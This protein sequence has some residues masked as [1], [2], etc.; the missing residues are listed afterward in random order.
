MLINSKHTTANKFYLWSCF[1][2]NSWI[3]NL[4]EFKIVYVI[5]SMYVIHYSFYLKRKKKKHTRHDR[6]FWWST[7]LI[8]FFALKTDYVYCMASLSRLISPTDE[9]M[10]IHIL[11]LYNLI[12]TG[13][14]WN[15]IIKWWKNLITQNQ[16]FIP[17]FF[18]FILRQAI[19][20]ICIDRYSIAFKTTHKQHIL[21]L[22]INTHECLPLWNT[23]K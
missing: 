6:P 22:D 18:I 9:I 12:S 21:F 20:S 16:M 10:N 3:E 17:L 1:L 14:L 13:F 23:T 7:F 5:K 19:H 11:K 8:W 4:L 15:S 2:E